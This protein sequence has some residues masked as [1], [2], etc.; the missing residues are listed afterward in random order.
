MARVV[1][2]SP[3]WYRI[4]TL[5][6]RE[7]VRP[8]PRQNIAANCGRTVTRD[9]SSSDLSRVT[10]RAVLTGKHGTLVRRAPGWQGAPDDQQAKN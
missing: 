9:D 3:C 2:A 1:N 6:A 5:M 8:R 10:A 7:R 4:W